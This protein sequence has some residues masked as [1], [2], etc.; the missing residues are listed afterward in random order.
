MHQTADIPIINSD[1]YSLFT[2]RE[3]RSPLGI[4]GERAF[5]KV[6]RLHNILVY[7]KPCKRQTQAIAE[8]G[9]YMLV[10]VLKPCIQK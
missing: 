6:N 3:P 10:T 2:P 9:I 5:P 1:A 7:L 4:D 8:V